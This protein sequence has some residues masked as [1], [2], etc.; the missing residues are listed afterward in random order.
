MSG[1]ERPGFEPWPYQLLAVVVFK[2]LFNFPVPQFSHRLG[3][4]WIASFPSYC[5]DQERLLP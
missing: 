3:G 1:H 4:N 5:E 2:Q